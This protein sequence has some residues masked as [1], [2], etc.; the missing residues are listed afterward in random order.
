MDTSK[1]MATD[2]KEPK[3]SEQREAQS[4]PTPSKPQYPDSAD[5]DAITLYLMRLPVFSPI[6]KKKA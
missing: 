4:T 3:R 6:T 2:P 1:S 5:V